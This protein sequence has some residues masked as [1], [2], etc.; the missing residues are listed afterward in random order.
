MTQT[1]NDAPPPSSSGRK[2]LVGGPA[3]TEF[4]IGKRDRKSVR[5]LYGQLD[6]LP[7]WRLEAN[8][9]LYAYP[10]ELTEVFEQRAAEAKAAQIAA[11]AAKAAEK[12][13]AA[14]AAAPKRQLA[15]PRGRRRPRRLRR[16]VGAAG[17]ARAEAEIT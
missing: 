10:D 8:G 11:A 3:I 13:A 6:K 4:L 16:D 14:R 1:F 2:L 7:I 12:K 15:P 17:A 5:W 9:Q